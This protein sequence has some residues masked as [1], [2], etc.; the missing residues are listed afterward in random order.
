MYVAVERLV[1]QPSVS[2]TFL[3]FSNCETPRNKLGVCCRHVDQLTGGL[4]ILL[5]NETP[6]AALDDLT[7]THSRQVCPSRAV[8]QSSSPKPY[9]RIPIIQQP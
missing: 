3:S 8:G 6:T 5:V 9:Q 1:E 7:S 4:S 2:I